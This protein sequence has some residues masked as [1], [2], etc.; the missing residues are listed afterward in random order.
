MDPSPA[1]L[2][3]L[4]ARVGA[5]D[6]RRPDAPPDPKTTAVMLAERDD[7]GFVIGLAWR[8]T[9]ADPAELYV[10]PER[11]R[12]GIGR[13]LAE[14]LLADDRARSGLWAHGT[15]PAAAHLAAALGLTPT[16]ELLQMRADLPATVDAALPAGT[17]IRTFE[18]GADDTEFL[19]VNAAAFAWHPEQ[20]RLDQA[21][22]DAEKAE[23]WFDPAG[24]F[25]AV[26]AGDREPGGRVLGFHWTKIHPAGSDAPEALGEIY[27]LGVDPASPVRHLGTPLTAAGLDHL[28]GRG[29]TRALLYVESDND[30]AL[31]IYRRYGFEVHAVDTVYAAR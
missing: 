29:L 9:E 3:D 15:L 16:R 6:G 25:L 31:G 27:V 23:T 24:F 22:L 11:R 2:E 10:D 18:P 12:R 19:R 4:L 17:V 14:R 30:R 5:A 1:E 7:A 13:R 21:G 20:G 28:A 8:P 26:P